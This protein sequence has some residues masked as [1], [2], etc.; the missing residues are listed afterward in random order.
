MKTTQDIIIL[1]NSF[2]QKNYFLQWN[3]TAAGS[4]Q[5]NISRLYFLKKTKKNIFQHSK[6]KVSATETTDNCY[7]VHVEN[8]NHEDQPINYKFQQKSM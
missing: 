5:S 3:A 8:N 2:F 1:D 6:A 4:S 7:N